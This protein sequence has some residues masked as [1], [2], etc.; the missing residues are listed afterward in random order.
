MENPLQKCEICAEAGP[1]QTKLPQHYIRKKFKAETH[2]ELSDEDLCDKRLFEIERDVY[3][4]K[5]LI[6]RWTLTCEDDK[7]TQPANF[8]NCTRQYLC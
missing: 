1:N 7:C 8:Y 6:E 3:C 2:L 4:V 5:E